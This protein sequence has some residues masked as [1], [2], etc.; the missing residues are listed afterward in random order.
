MELSQKKKMQNNFLEEQMAENKP[1]GG[2]KRK[3]AKAKLCE[4]RGS[5]KEDVRKEELYKMRKSLEKI[6]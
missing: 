4:K 1:K 3:A 6:S 2:A 5:L